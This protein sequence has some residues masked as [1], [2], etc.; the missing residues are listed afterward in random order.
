MRNL[1]EATCI[2]ANFAVILGREKSGL[3]V[4]H[5]DPNL[6]CPGHLFRSNC[7]GLSREESERPGEVS[8]KNPK[9]VDQARLILVVPAGFE[10]VDFERVHTKILVPTTPNGGP[11]LSLLISHNL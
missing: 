6:F 1:S 7:R 2:P 10:T 8:I 3:P 4:L 11:D 5:S 9:V